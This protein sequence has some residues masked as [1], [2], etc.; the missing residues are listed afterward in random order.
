MFDLSMAAA[1]WW[2]S[3]GLPC[4]GGGRIVMHTPRKTTRGRRLIVGA[5]AAAA[6]CIG[7]GIVTCW[8]QT[9]AAAAPMIISGTVASVDAKQ[10]LITVKRGFF[11]TQTFAVDANTRITQG[12]QPLPLER[13]QAGADVTIAYVEEREQRIAQAINVHNQPATERAPDRR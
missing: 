8:T 1:V 2:T 4:N 9:V 7:G 11:A 3:M 6:L 12:E 10:N 5:L 13:L